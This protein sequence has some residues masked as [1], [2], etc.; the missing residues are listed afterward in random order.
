[1]KLPIPNDWNGTDFCRWAVC[2]PDS[3]QWKAA[4]Y[5]LVEMPMQGRFWDF[6]TGDFIQ[7]REQFRPAY[8]HNFNLREVIMS[9]GDN[10]LQEIAQAIRAL[11]IAM[12]AQATASASCCGQGSVGQGQTPVPY[13]PIEEGDPD[14][15]PPP[16]GF[17][18]WEQFFANKCSV[19]TDI[20]TTLQADIGRMTTINLV[21]ITLVALIPVLIGL[22]LTPIPGDEIAVIA[23]VLLGVLALGGAMLD[24]ISDTITAHFEELV[25]SLYNANSSASAETDFE[26]AFSTAWSTEGYDTT[27][28][29]ISAKS[30]INSMVGSA[31][32]NKLFELQSDRILP[33][34]DCSGCVCEAQ[35]DFGTDTGG[36]VIESEWF[37]NPPQ[38]HYRVQITTVGNCCKGMTLTDITGFTPTGYPN[39]DVYVSICGTDPLTTN[40]PNEALDNEYSC[41][42]FTIRSLTPFTA[43]FTIQD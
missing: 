43:T 20:V 12:T 19:A 11:S 6:S 27:P 33:A 25:C 16:D 10:G 21:G 17:D 41:I 5:G 24:N 2:W 15:D 14:T 38:S 18:T 40:D 29:S 9:C 13:N 34:G 8:Q 35:I 28:Y 39:T 32:T 3:P 22:L 4:L 31:S 37:E 42:E 23:G 7:T 26:E 1:M 30:L 36:W